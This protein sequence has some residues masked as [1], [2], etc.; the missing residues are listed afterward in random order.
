MPI[1]VACVCGKLTMVA[2]SFGGRSGKCR[3]C[4]ASIL[5]PALPAADL[6]PTPAVLLDL[7][8]DDG[9]PVSR[10]ASAAVISGEPW[11][12]RFL[13]AYATGLFWLAL[14]Q[15]G[16]GLAVAVAICLRSE[17]GTFSYAAFVPFAISVAALVGLWLASASVMVLVDAGR[18]LR[19]MAG[20][21]R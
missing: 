10:P 18:S 4:G 5:V 9:D 11:Y 13:E 3:S 6:E 17:E 15:A 20:R 14:C 2:D 8:T 16:L 19:V 1:E 12:Y 7:V 21:S